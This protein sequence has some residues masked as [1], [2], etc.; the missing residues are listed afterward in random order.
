MAERSAAADWHV[1]TQSIDRFS[2]LCNTAVMTARRRN[3]DRLLTKSEKIQ[4]LIFDLGDT[5]IEQV[6]DR[7]APLPDHALRLL[8]GVERALRELAKRYE[9]AIL[10]NTEQTTTVQL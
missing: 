8:P 2:A 3:N 4:L 10:S 1:A 6:V 5:L 9:L 7:A